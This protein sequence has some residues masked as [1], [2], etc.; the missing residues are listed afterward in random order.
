[1][2]GIN[3]SKI[4]VASASTIASKDFFTAAGKSSAS[5]ILP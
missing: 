5:M 1:M 3:A 4:N 2:T